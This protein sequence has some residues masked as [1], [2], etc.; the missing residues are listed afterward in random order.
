MLSG[1]NDT[2]EDAQRLVQL[3]EGV[4]VKVRWRSF[5]IFYSRAKGCSSTADWLI[6]ALSFV[7]A[8]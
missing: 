8:C 1:V 3:L 5:S 2:L 7:L 4:E 6:H